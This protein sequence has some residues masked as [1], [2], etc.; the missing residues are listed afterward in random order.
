M[1]QMLPKAARPD[2]QAAESAMLDG[3]E[4]V[5]HVAHRLSETIAIYPITPSSTMAELA[6]EWS[7][8]GRT[9][10]WGG[11]PQALGLPSEAH[12][13]ANSPIGDDG[14]MG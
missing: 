1:S 3:N 12:W 4:A 8:Q 13:S 10:L 11:V 7:S 2:L 5:A 6:D 14:V 9:N